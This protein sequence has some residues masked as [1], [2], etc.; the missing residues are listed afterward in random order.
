MP[1]PRLLN[2]MREHLI[3]QGVVRRPSVAAAA[4]PMWL[5]PTLGTP[6]P[7][8]GDVPVEVDQ[9]LVLGAF[10]TG[11]FAPE[12]YGSW[13]RRPIVD[14]RIRAAKDEAYRAEDVELAMSKALID[15]RDWTMGGLYVIESEQWRAL[16]RLSSDAKGTEYVVA[17]TFELLRQ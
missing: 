15:R 5:E 10:L 7:G 3:A 13:H 1:A 14:V 17:Y 6:A 4:P 8:D 9:Y 12:P 11:G 16:Q 2:A